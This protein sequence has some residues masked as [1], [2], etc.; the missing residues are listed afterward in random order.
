M[1]ARLYRGSIWHAR[2]EPLRHVFAYPAA[3]VTVELGALRDA[4]FG[5]RLAY[6][7]PAFLSIRDQDYLAPGQQPI[8]EKLARLMPGFDHRRTIMLTVPRLLARSFNP[9]T[10]YFAHDEAG[11]VTGFAVE[12]SNTYGE[13][14]FYTLEPVRAP[15]GRLTATTPKAM[16]VSP[17]HGVKGQYRFA[18]TLTPDIVELSV[19]L[20]VDGRVLVAARLSGRGKPLAEASLLDLARVGLTGILAWPRI[21]GQALKLRAKGLRPVMKPRPPADALR[22]ASGR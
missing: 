6:N 11:A 13:R 12:V 3:F 4:S 10:A 5:W 8:A 22:K 9:L 21:V 20:E 2:T 18:A 14:Y 17:F 7:R 1:S 16:Y 15:D 19:D